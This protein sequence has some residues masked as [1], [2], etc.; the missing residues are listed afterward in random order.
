MIYWKLMAPM[1]L[2]NLEFIS[3][4]KSFGHFHCLKDNDRAIVKFSN[5]KDSLQ[6]LC[7]KEDLKSLGMTNLE[8][9]EGT[10]IFV[11]ESVCDYYRG[12]CNKCKKTK[13]TVKLNVSFASNGTIKIKALEKVQPNP[14][15]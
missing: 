4:G 10:K 8:F 2:I 1:Y 12:L 3:W 11:N 5:S 7:V 6:I 14:L 9:L 15:L 13:S